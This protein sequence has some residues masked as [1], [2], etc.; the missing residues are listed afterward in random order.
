NRSPVAP[1]RSPAS[2]STNTGSQR[3][4]G[5]S[6]TASTPATML[7]Q[8]CSSEPAPGNTQAMPTIATPS[9]RPSTTERP[10]LQH[11]DVDGGGRDRVRAAGPHGREGRGRG[12]HDPLRSGGPRGSAHRVE[13][14]LDALVGV[15]EADAPPA[16]LALQLG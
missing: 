16:V 9:V 10:V 4:A 13:E 6:V 7:A 3:L 2:G 12:A 14:R 5:T 11:P 1:V 15:D 8:Y